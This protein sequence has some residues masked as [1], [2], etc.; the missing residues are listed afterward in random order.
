[1]QDHLFT[2]YVQRLEAPVETL[3]PKDRNQVLQF[4]F[5]GSLGN[6]FFL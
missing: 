4:T 3:Q 5:P 6:Q 2:E 1:M